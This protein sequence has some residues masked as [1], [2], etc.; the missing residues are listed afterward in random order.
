[1]AYREAY[2]Q[3]ARSRRAWLLAALV[4]CAALILA[5]RLFQLQVLGVREYT[6]QSERNRVRVERFAAPRGLIVD[7]FGAVLAD[8]RPSYT[9]RA[10][11]RRVLRDEARLPLLSRL[12]DIPVDE[13]TERLRK[14]GSSH[15]PAPVCRDASF[16][17]VSRIAEHEEDLPGVSL[18]VS[19]VRWYPNGSAAAH[20]LGHVGEISEKEV[21]RLADRGYRAGD[22][23]GRTG[24]EKQYEDVLRGV[25]GERWLEVDAVGRIV[26]GF[27]ADRSVPAIPGRTLRLWLD[28]PLQAL[29]DSCLAGRR[30]SVCML[31]VAS[32]GVL[33]LESSPGFDPNVFAAGVRPGE[34]RRLNGD[35]ERPMLFRA[36]QSAYAPGSTFKMV[37]FAVTLEEHVAGFSQRLPASCIGG[38]RFGNRFWRCW[39]PKGHGPL[40]LEDALVKSCDVYFY[41]VGE[42]VPVDTLAHA[43]MAA[44]LGRRTGVD[45]PEEAPGLVPTSE[46]L[47]R[48][49]GK[50][51]WTQ[52]AVL[53]HAIGQGEYLTTPLQLARYA[54]T[55]ARG[56]SIPVPRI[57]QA[58]EGPDGVMQ[59]TEPRTDGTWAISA[60]TMERIR[61]AMH[62]VV[63]RGTAR[64][65]R[66]EGYMP[67]GKTGTAENPHGEAHS[68]F[69][70]YAPYDAPEVAFSVMVEAGGHGS[71]VAA[72][73]AKR[74]LQE[75]ASRRAPPLD[76]I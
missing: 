40:A 73:I 41:Q 33:V 45:L 26:G 22:F 32:G 51:G 24:I 10:V 1:M 54:A 66:I 49:W 19:T 44:G 4:G 36:V 76:G 56:G 50:R 7:R 60:E 23:L 61:E 67:A 68:W 8:S 71:D 15:S 47:D 37:T 46:W 59:E 72:P 58:I 43:A 18:D 5:G 12:L 70:G 6:L 2:H 35:P 9:V 74:L 42:R 31:D 20:L 14:G 11:P 57:V 63:E 30:G 75:L 52:G 28:L 25:D 62:Q 64:V 29:A 65:C 34:W 3:Q 21:E 17:Q 27:A 53:N 38:Y 69:M 16:V 55:L 39:E 48:R 13:I